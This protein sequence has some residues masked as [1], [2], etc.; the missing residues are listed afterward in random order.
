METLNFEENA[1]P[2]CLSQD[3][4]RL[5]M[6]YLL[7]TLRDTEGPVR[8]LDFAPNNAFSARLRKHPK[9]LYTSV[10]LTRTDV[11]LNIDICNMSSFEN[12]RF[13]F[14]IC[15]HVLEHVEDVAQ[16]LQEIHRVL[17]LG[18]RAIIMVPLF[19]DVFETVEDTSITSPVRRRRLFGQDDHV[20]LFARHDFVNSIEAAGFTVQQLLPRDFDGEL[21]HQNAIPDNSILY[22]CHRN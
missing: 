16:A 15:S 13:H 9:C 2:F 10:D 17:C 8:I 21:L 11:D 18:G 20:R 22:V 14:I 19:W 12:G 4:E 7:Q 1:C 3:R 5:Y 6:I